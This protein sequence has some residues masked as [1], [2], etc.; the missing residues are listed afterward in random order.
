MLQH[1]LERVD[2]LAQRPFLV[3]PGLRLRRMCDLECREAAKE[4]SATG[5]SRW[6]RLLVFQ[7]GRL[8]AALRVRVGVR[9]E[10]SNGTQS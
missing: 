4:A 8:P 6:G 1:F 7:A 2:D 5:R 3:G 10:V 9:A